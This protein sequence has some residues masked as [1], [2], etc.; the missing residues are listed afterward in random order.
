MLKFLNFKTF[1]SLIVIIL[2]ASTIYASSGSNSGN[3][4]WGES[5]VTTTTGGGSSCYV[6]KTTCTQ[7]IFWIPVGSSTHIDNIDCSNIDTGTQNQST[8]LE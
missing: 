2:F 1:L 3:P 6:T 7:Y 5:C 8:G 4:F